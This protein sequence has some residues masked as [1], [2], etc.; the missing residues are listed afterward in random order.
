MQAKSFRIEGTPDNPSDWDVTICSLGAFGTIYEHINPVTAF[1]NLQQGHQAAVL[2]IDHIMSRPD[3][4][5]TNVLNINLRQ[6]VGSGLP[7]VQ[8]SNDVVAAT[9]SF[10]PSPPLGN[11]ELILESIDLNSPLTSPAVLKTN[12]IT[13]NVYGTNEG[14]FKYGVL[15]KAGQTHLMSLN[16]E[17]YTGNQGF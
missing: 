10:D 3:V 14:A 9:L 7:W 1:I 8:I 5:I 13:V 17:L 6:K 2:T 16:Y 15:P 11:Y 12:V 4:K